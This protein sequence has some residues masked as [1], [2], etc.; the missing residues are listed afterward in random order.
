MQ[1]SPADPPTGFWSRL[2]LAGRLL[3]AFWGVVAA[4]GGA[5][6]VLVSHETPQQ[7][8]PPG[9]A[10]P[11]ARPVPLAA[12]PP[13]R[14]VP[15]PAPVTA[16]P[17]AAVSPSSPAPEA[18]AQAPDAGATAAAANPAAIVASGKTALAVVLQ[19][20]GYSDALSYSAL[21]RLPAPVAVAVSPYIGGIAD[22]IARAKAS[23]REVYVD[24]PMQSAHPDRVDEGPH[25]LGY[26]NSP[27][28]DRRE[29]EWCLGR[30]KGAT[31]LTDA[32]D[33]GDDQSGGGFATTADFR[34]IAEAISRA[35]LLFLSVSGADIRQTRGMTVSAWVDGDADATTIDSRLASLL[36]G[37]TVAGTSAPLSGAPP[38]R[39]LI[40]V[41]P[42]TPV[43]IDRLAAW[44]AGP[45]A[46]SAVLVPP[47]ALADSGGFASAVP[48]AAPS[49][50]P[51]S[52]SGAPLPAPNKVK[53]V[54]D[55]ARPVEASPL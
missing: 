53:A 44:L 49:P 18:V 3:V 20:F 2:P 32:S 28:D 19:G 54:S 36:P 31:G 24:L 42:L 46:K 9:P 30:A 45:A 51:D 48:A 43:A 6:A 29:L 14:P 22:V 39:L 34:P 13:P 41:S 5:L 33:G 52:S 38:A 25:A 16:P 21:S 7:A 26:G 55:R 15:V 35:G 1:N 47:S 23:H 50:S 37:G 12:A 40:M 17:S 27:S 4:G 8:P 11:A 10:A